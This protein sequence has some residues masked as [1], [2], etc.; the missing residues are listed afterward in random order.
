L[1]LIYLRQT[2]L[3]NFIIS[4]VQK[5]LELVLLN[6]MLVTLKLLLVVLE[7][8]K[9]TLVVFEL[10]INKL[11]IYT[12]VTLHIQE[13]QTTHTHINIILFYYLYLKFY[14]NSSLEFNS[15]LIA[16]KKIKKSFSISRD[17]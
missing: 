9:N 5:T 17:I 14:L 15:L 1:S 2:K 7:L 8:V 4:Q 13:M 16:K 11:D 12:F 10:K 3:S 6:L